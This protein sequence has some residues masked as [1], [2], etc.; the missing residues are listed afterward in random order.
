MLDTDSISF[1]LRGEGRV[2]NRIL[3]HRPSELCVSAITVAELRYG[4]ERRKSSRLHALVDTF[5][6][7]IAIMPFDE[8]AARHFGTLA[9]D[10]ALRGTPFGQ[11]DVLI[12][13]HAIAVSAVLVTNDPK[14]FV[15]VEGLVV[16]NW[17]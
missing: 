9:A 13:A 2:G 14:R 17:V 7:N 8:S 16:E 1:A 10:L 4:V 6:S 15:R 12:G 11:Y 3:E 5:L